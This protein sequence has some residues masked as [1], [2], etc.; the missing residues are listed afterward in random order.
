MPAFREEM[1]LK[2][3]T[4]ERNSD[5][6]CLCFW[7]VGSSTLTTPTTEKVF[8]D[9]SLPD[10]LSSS[11]NTIQS[12]S[13]R[14]PANAGGQNT[15][16][17]K[18]SN[19]E[20][21]AI[22]EREA[23]RA[24]ERESCFSLSVAGEMP[25]D[26]ILAR[27]LA[28]SLTPLL[29]SSLHPTPHPLIHQIRDSQAQTLRS[30]TVKQLHDVSRMGRRKGRGR[31]K[32]NDTDAFLASVRKSQRSSSFSSL[33]CPSSSPSSPRRTPSPTLTHQTGHRR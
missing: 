22:E 15:P 5:A 27:S 20:A 18:V 19:A 26:E 10:A 28:R 23:A 29:F 3:A 9:S 31:G 6:L 21:A 16:G 30:L 24:P 7:F 8:Q 2:Y 12:T 32:K 11:L 14:S 4:A 13:H 1:T 25:I 17:E 33:S